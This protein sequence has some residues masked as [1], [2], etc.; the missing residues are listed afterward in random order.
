MTLTYAMPTSSGLIIF[1]ARLLYSL[2]KKY[3]GQPFDIRLIGLLYSALFLLAVTEMLR[4][5]AVW[6]E[7]RPF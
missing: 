7:T 5:F 2:L 3:N 1:I 4:L 6:N